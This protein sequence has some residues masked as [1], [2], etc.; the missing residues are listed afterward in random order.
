MRLFARPLCIT[1]IIRDTTYDLD[2]LFIAIYNCIP[3]PPQTP[4]MPYTETIRMKPC[5]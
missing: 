2:K 3:Q 5:T 1:H 4:N